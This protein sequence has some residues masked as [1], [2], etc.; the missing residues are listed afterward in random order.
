VLVQENT[1]R[2]AWDQWAGMG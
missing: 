1:G 2:K